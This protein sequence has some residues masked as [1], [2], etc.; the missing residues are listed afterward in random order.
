ADI[1]IPALVDFADGL[2]HCLGHPIGGVTSQVFG[3]RSTVDVASGSLRASREAL[4]LLEHFIGNR[5]RSFHTRSITDQGFGSNWAGSTRARGSGASR[6]SS[7]G[8]R[9]SPPA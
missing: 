2:V 3:Q 5:H 4:R 9:P 1:T 8:W 6:G 7:R